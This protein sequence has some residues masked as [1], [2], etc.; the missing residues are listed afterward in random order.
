MGDSVNIQNLLQAG[1]FT[2]SRSRSRSPRQDELHQEQ[3][4]RSVGRSCDDR[5]DYDSPYDRPR[6]SPSPIRLPPPPSRTVPRS[7]PTPPRP[8]VD[9]EVSILNKEPAYTKTVA[10][11]EEAASRGDVD[12]AQTIMEVHEFNPERRFVILDDESATNISGDKSDSVKEDTGAGPKV[13]ED[14][15]PDI[16]SDKSAEQ[17]PRARSAGLSPPPSSGR[18][19]SRHDL[20]VLETEFSDRQYTEHHRSRSAVNGPRPDYFNP[21]RSSRFYGDQL[22]S[23]DLTKQS[24][25]GR[26]D[27]YY[28]ADYRDR[29]RETVR[30][31][32][33]VSS[34]KAYEFD[35]QRQRS[36]QSRLL[37]DFFSGNPVLQTSPGFFERIPGFFERIHEVL[38]TH[39][40]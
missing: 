40:S 1:Y 36:S 14:S 37:F 22:L 2:T 25:R 33:R 9:D 18:R 34:T 28:G 15:K 30:H 5:Y 24:S 4:Y 19:R 3:D 20:P 26:E 8:T 32:V 13:T 6:R 7:R 31:S 16:P 11:E 27:G 23:P 17:H 39:L 10:S 29:P 21:S 12:Q 35:R 38:D